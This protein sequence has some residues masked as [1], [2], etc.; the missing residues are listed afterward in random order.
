MQSACTVLRHLWPLWLHHI[1]PNYLINVMIFGK[2]KKVFNITRFL[3]SL[4]FFFWCFSH[5]KQSPAKYAYKCKNV[6]TYALFL[7]QFNETLILFTDF[8]KKNTNTKFCQTPHI[9]NRVFPSYVFLQKNWNSRVTF[10]RMTYADHIEKRRASV[11][12]LH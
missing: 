11:R 5:S 1:S 12:C 7:S 6:F 2:K 4:Q 8:R 9:G 10:L 3:F